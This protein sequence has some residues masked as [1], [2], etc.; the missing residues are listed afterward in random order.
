MHR[1]LGKVQVSEEA[2]ESREYPARFRPVERFYG[3]AELFGHWRRH[4]RKASKRKRRTQ[5][6][7]F[8]RMLTEEVKS[9][10]IRVADGRAEAALPSFA[11]L[12]FDVG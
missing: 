3:L 7:K 6:H 8:E 2:H 1:L 5:I 11:I 12:S 10:E 9:S 4:L